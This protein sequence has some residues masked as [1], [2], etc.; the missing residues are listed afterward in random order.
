[1]LNL[2]ISAMKPLQQSHTHIT[3]L[4]CPLEWSGECIIREKSGE[5]FLGEKSLPI[6][7]GRWP[8]IPQP[9]AITVAIPPMVVICRESGGDLPRLSSHWAKGA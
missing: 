7:H 9:L 3:I 4:E 5:N 1:M 2:V 8:T 6:Q